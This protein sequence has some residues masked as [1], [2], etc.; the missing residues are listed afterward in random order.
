MALNSKV[1]LIHLSGDERLAQSLIEGEKNATKNIQVQTA[2]VNDCGK[3]WRDLMTKYDRSI[4]SIIKKKKKN[5]RLVSDVERDHVARER[6]NNW[7][8]KNS[9]NARETEAKKQTLPQSFTLLRNTDNSV[10]FF[11]LKIN[12]LHVLYSSPT[13]SI[14]PHH[15]GSFAINSR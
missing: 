6:L 2:L 4:F 15:F 13:S 7:T 10:A 9:K 12:G 11:A 3:L 5:W 14:S 8:R 1:K